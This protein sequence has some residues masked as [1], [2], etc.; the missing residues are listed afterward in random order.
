MQRFVIKNNAYNG[1]N[2]H[3]LLT[4]FSVWRRD[5]EWWYIAIGV[6]QL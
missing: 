2:F 4:T 3:P 1:K 5:L 6:S